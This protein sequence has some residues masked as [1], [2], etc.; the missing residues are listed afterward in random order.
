MLL[1]FFDVFGR[2]IFNAPISGSN[3]LTEIAMGMIVYIGL[4]LVCIRREHITIG[5]LAGLFRGRLLRWQHVILNL[6]F[7]AVSFVWARQ[8]WVQAQSMAD[9]NAVKMFLQI[10]VAPY[11]FGMSALTFFSAVLFLFLAWCYAR[12][13][14][15]KTG[16]AMA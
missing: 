11:V 4:P 6:I 9:S 2:Q 13:A 7:A 1:T 15:P 8:M 10:S 14:T 16:G 5:L 3:E 12:G